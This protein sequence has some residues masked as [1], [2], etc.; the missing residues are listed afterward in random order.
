MN[1]DVCMDPI[2]ERLYSHVSFPGANSPT[3]MYIHMYLYIYIYAWRI[4]PTN[5]VSQGGKA[6]LNERAIGF[7]LGDSL[8]FGAHICGTKPTNEAR[9]ASW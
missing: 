1:E 9:T 4:D 7:P 8:V 2:K 5:W 6:L 3:I